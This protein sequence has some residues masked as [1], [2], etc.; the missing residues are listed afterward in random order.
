MRR[1]W[2][3]GAAEEATGVAQPTCPQTRLHAPDGYIGRFLKVVWQI[4]KD[5]FMAAIERVF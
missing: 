5:D 4:I 3:R 2:T 1:V